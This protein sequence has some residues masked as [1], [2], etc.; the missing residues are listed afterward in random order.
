MIILF[1]HYFLSFTGQTTI[2]KLITVMT[3]PGAFPMAQRVKNL[4]AMQETQKTGVWFLG[5]EDPGGGYGNTFQH[6]CLEKPL[7][8]GPWRATVHRV[9]KSQT[10]LRQ[11]STKRSDK[12]FDAKFFLL[13]HR[14]PLLY[15]RVFTKFSH[16]VSFHKL[17]PL[18]SD[19]LT[20]LVVLYLLI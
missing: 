17:D 9:S 6:S 12:S 7:E 11:L 4:P 3:I 1:I 2:I 13:S 15:Q 20:S 10:Q 8:R 14:I 18:Y 19:P 5:W 16:P